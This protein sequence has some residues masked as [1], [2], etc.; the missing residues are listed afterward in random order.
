MA[1]MILLEDI[2]APM[3]E[4]YSSSN[5]QVVRGSANIALCPDVIVVSVFISET[6]TSLIDVSLSHIRDSSRL[7]DGKFSNLE[8]SCPISFWKI[9]SSQA[10]SP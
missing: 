8:V 4:V 2:A 6:R 9:T 5:Y 10:M 3:G 7:V 1:I